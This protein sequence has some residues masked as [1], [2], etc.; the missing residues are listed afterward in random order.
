[1][2]TLGIFGLLVGLVIAGVPIAISLAL[3]AI[4]AM[5]WQGGRH[6]AHHALPAD[7]RG[8]DLVPAARRPLLHPRRQPDEHRRHDA[9]HLRRGPARRG[10]PARRA[11]AGQRRRQ[12][13][14]RRHV[15]LGRGRCGGPRHDRDPGHGGGRLRPPLRRS[16]HRRR[17]HHRPGDPAQ[18]P[19]RHL[20][21]T[22]QRLGGCA[23]PRRHRP[24]PPHGRRPDAGGGADGA[25]P[26]HAG[27]AR[28]TRRRRGRADRARRGPGA[29][30]PDPRRR[31][32]PHRLRHPH[33]GRRPGPRSTPWPWASSSTASSPCAGCPSSSGPRARRPCRCS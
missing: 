19:V 13:H 26:G 8:H 22:G 14:L 21:R 15:G 4:G 23:L 11:G 16:A 32:H 2:L 31:R 27:I 18:H 1:M 12:R 6:A 10:A 30:H 9:A 20:R 33:R 7:V 24:R 29:P 17:L 28:P 25:A 5:W 3:T